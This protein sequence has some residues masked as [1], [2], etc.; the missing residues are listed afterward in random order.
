[1]YISLS[2][3]NILDRL[4]AN[5][6]ALIDEISDEFICPVTKELLVDPYQS[7]CCGHYISKEAFDKLLTQE[8]KC[9]MCRSISWR[10]TPDKAFQRR[11]HQA[12]KV[13]CLLHN[14]CNWTGPFS[15]FLQHCGISIND[16]SSTK[17]MSPIVTKNVNDFSMHIA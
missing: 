11:V 5:S 13:R 4:A 15:D 9:P 12:L 3:M 16:A 17:S 2:V 10:C 1:M 7:L 6:Y 14:G 8:A